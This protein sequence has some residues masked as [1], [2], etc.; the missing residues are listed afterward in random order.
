M[1]YDYSF[2]SEMTPECISYCLDCWERAEVCS[3]DHSYGM[4]EADLPYV[5]ESYAELY[6]EL[7][8]C[9][10]CPLRGDEPVKSK[11]KKRAK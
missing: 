1:K 6:S 7:P 3:C 9:R 10:P 4:G 8:E 11:K 2:S 5:E